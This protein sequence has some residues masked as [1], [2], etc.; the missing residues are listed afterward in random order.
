MARRKAEL[1][2]TIDLLDG[3]IRSGASQGD[4]GPR[5]ALVKHRQDH[6][7]LNNAELHLAN[8]IQHRVSQAAQP[9]SSPAPN[10]VSP[11]QGPGWSQFQVSQFQ[12]Q[13]QQLMQH[14]L[15]QQQQ[16]QGPNAQQQVALLQAQAKATQV[17]AQQQQAQESLRNQ[18]QQAAQQQARVPTPSGQPQSSQPPQSQT[19]GLPQTSGKIHLPT[20]PM[21]W[22][23]F[24]NFVKQNNL[25]VSDIPQIGNDQIDLFKLFVEVL[26]LGG[27]EKVRV[28]AGIIC[29]K[30]AGEF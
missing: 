28:G 27:C 13:Q 17:Q 15:Q 24:Q 1:Q 9:T 14:A 22:T 30:G 29:Q 12:Q 8:L 4:P 3:H 2:K 20:Q 11:S 6:E 18:Q 23:Y 5:M 7:I 16:Q 19:P 25:N 21:F 26:K 10:H